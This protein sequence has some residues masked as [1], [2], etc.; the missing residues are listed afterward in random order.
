MTRIDHPTRPAWQSPVV[1]GVALLSLVAA[2]LLV[3]VLL[4][5][6]DGTA[7]ASPTPSLTA[8]TP[9][10]PSVSASASAVASASAAPSAS[11]APPS[12]TEAPEPT[13]V[14]AAPDGLIPPGSV[15]RVLVDGL[16]IRESPSTDAT[17][18]SLAGGTLVSVG[19]S[20]HI[21][22]WGPIEADGLT[23]YPVRAFVTDTLPDVPSP[24]Q[25]ASEA[26]GWVAAG[27]GTE[28]FIELFDPRCTL[29]TPTLEIIQSLEPWERLACYGSE[30]MTIEGTFGCGGCGGLFA[31]TFEPAWLAA[32]GGFDLLSVDPQ[33]RIGPFVIYFPPEVERL[34]GGEIVR[35]TGHFDDP[36]ATG[37]VVS[38]GDPPAEID[39][40]TAVLYCR[41]RFVV[42]SVEILGTDEGF[43]FG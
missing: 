13:P 16:R 6:D 32:P 29:A 34:S 8:S 19:F 28:P 17:F 25:E 31:G 20:G 7:Q 12:A 10:A 38:P 22:D 5:G 43:P 26:F 24:I 11:Q 1:I 36:A 27:D 9:S 3:A 2:A 41:E 14:V 40:R 18:T 39:E 35:L 42:E 30:S 21:S 15:A 37:C 33:E 4:G 23:W